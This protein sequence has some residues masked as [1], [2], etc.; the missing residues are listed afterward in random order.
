MACFIIGCRLASPG[1]DYVA[2]TEG[3]ERLGKSWECPGSSWILS[4]DLCAA[5]IRDSLRPC[6]G[7]ND[8]LF[9]AQV[10]GEVAWGGASSGFADGLRTV[11]G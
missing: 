1:G 4:T 6:L 9:V 5:E 3:I 8:Q 2:I 11:L 7:A 10:R